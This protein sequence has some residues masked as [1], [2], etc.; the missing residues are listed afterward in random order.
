MET[1]FIPSGQDEDYQSTT[2][3]PTGDLNDINCILQV[4]LGMPAATGIICRFTNIIEWKPLP[5]IGI[6]SESFLGN[7]SKNTIEHVKNALLKRNPGW[8]SNIGN[9]AYSVLRGYATGGSI[10]AI[11]AAM[12]SVKFM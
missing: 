7:P 10:G 6:V 12:K 9:A 2:V 4:F 8:W 1:K 11:S 5:N 3:I